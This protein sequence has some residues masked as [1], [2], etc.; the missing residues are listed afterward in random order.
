MPE[1]DVDIKDFLSVIPSNLKDIYQKAQISLSRII[2]DIKKE[3]A[4]RDAVVKEIED[5]EKKISYLKEDY[6]RFERDLESQKKIKVKEME[7]FIDTEKEHI[8]SL[9]S[10]LQSKSASLDEKLKGVEF[11]SIRLKEAVAANEG[12]IE[13]RTKIVEELETLVRDIQERLKK[14]VA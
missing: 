5:L 9:R 11:N 13:T 6:V 2:S 8:V 4:R 14:Y 3:S 7:D 10:E 12:L 1:E